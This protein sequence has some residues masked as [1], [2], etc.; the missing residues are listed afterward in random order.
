MKA[1]DEKIM[2]Q[3]YFKKMSTIF[4]IIKLNH[5]NFENSESSLT[6]KYI[7]KVNKSL[8]ELKIIN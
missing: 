4:L 3:C 1:L 2:A 6:Y 5:E 7:R 8:I